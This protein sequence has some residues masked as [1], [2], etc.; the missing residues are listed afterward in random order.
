M[1]DMLNLTDCEGQTPALRWAATRDIL[2]FPNCEGQTRKDTVRK[3]QL[4]NSEELVEAVLKT[5]AGRGV[6]SGIQ[7]RPLILLHT[8]GPKKL[9]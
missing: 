5:V 8:A 7:P 6:R 3:Q 1:R 2:M 4:L 9:T